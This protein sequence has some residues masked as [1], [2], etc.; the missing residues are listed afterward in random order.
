MTSPLVS[1]GTATLQAV[2]QNSAGRVAAAKLILEALPPAEMLLYDALE[3]GAYRLREP[4]SLRVAAEGGQAIVS[5]DEATLRGVGK[6][7]GEALSQFRAAVL[8]SAE[9]DDNTMVRQYIEHVS[10]P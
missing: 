2:A 4:I 3:S 9:R 10:L 6:T 7:F 1:Q 8:N 5:W